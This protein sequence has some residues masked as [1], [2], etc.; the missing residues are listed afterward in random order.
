M[1][2]NAEIHGNSSGRVFVLPRPV[3]RAGDRVMVVDD[4]SHLHFREVK[5]FRAEDDRVLVSSGLQ[6]GDRVI[7][8]ALETAVEGMRVQVE[9]AKPEGAAGPASTAAAA[10]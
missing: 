7:V 8:S 1:F 5:V 4:S 6:P 2:V 9:T 10:E 3:L